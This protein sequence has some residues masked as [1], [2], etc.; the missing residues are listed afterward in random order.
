VDGLLD[1]IP[2]DQA[3]SVI[4]VKSDNVPPGQQQKPEATHVAPAYDPSVVFALEFATVLAMRDEQ[5]VELFGKKV[6]ETLHSVL[7]DA[8]QHHHLVVSRT[9]F[10]L[11]NLLRASHVSRCVFFPI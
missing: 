10:Y 9:A 6:M 2:E 3:I 7:R 1:S 11:L 8:S 5:T 4:T